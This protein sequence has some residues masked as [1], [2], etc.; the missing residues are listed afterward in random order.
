MEGPVA[1]RPVGEWLTSDGPVVER[2]LGAAPL[3]VG[4]A[5]EGPVC[6]G[7]AAVEEPFGGRRT[8]EGAAGEGVLPGAPL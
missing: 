1:E 6:E 3:G 4:P 7:A 2:L 5:V 8:A